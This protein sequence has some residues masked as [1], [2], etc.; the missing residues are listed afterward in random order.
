MT[1]R[2][3]AGMF[4]PQRPKADFSISCNRFTASYNRWLSEM[5]DG[6]MN[7]KMWKDT[8]RKWE[9]LVGEIENNV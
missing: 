6:K 5:I 4:F 3:L 9:E 8:K 1:R 2:M 7:F